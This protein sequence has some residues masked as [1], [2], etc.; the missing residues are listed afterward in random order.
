MKPAQSPQVFLS[1]KRED[2]ARAARVA[3]A[4][5]HHG[6]AVWWDRQLPGGE[7]W[8][9][10]IEA[11]LDAAGC[12]VV[13]WTEGAVG[14]QG[15]YVRDEARRAQQ[16]QRLVPVLM[17]RVTPPLGLGEVQAVDLTHWKGSP[18]DP[19]LLDVVAA[20]RAKLEG[21]PVPPAKGPQLR[22]VRRLTAG[23]VTGALAT[24]AWVLAAHV[25]G[26]NEHTCTLPVGQPGLSDLCG[27]LGIGKRPRREERLAWEARTP[28]SCEAL[29]Q[30]V[31]RFPEGALRSSAAELLAAARSER[32]TTPVPAPRDGIGYVRLAPAGVATEAAARAQA[33]ERARADAETLTCKPLSPHERL[34]GVQIEPLT[35][36]CRRLSDGSNSCALDY[37]ARCGIEVLPVLER[38][39]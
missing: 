36:D 27:S 30:H 11:A 9:Q 7:S 10:N 8:H 29:R 39:G 25:F 24:V 6:L 23:G 18:R 34:M 3:R 22:W 38:C 35:F 12:V 2:E 17:D 21:R 33:V 4:L 26:L 13:L 19:F 1:Y 37:R 31:Q 28:G 32:A 15:G 16:R 5:A 14:P 20:V